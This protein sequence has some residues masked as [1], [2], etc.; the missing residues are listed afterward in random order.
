[1]GRRQRTRASCCALPSSALAI[2]FGRRKAD[3]VPKWGRRPLAAESMLG[4]IHALSPKDDLQR[5]LRGQALSLAFGLSES[6]WLFYEQSASSV[7][8]PMMVILVFWLTVI[9]IGFGLFAPRNA[10]VI[11]SLFIAALSISGAIFLIMEMYAPFSGVMHVSSG[12][13]RFAIAQ[14][15]Q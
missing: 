2:S 15:G 7:P 1:M 4:K 9:F 5:S 13:V 10:T 3:D 6:R 12:P 14:L 8:T 11:A